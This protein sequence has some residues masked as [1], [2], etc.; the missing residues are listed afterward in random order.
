MFQR[1]NDHS[2]FAH[3][4]FTQLQARFPSSSLITELVQIHGEQF[5]VRA[6]V[7]VSGTTLATGMAA[8]SSI[9]QAEDQARSRA[10]SVVGIV[11]PPVPPLP[12]VQPL[13]NGSSLAGPSPFPQSPSPAATLAMP[14]ALAVAPVSPVPPV[15]AMPPIGGLNPT[16]EPESKVEPE[17]N[18]TSKFSFQPDI[19]TAATIPP[20]MDAP[21]EPIPDDQGMISNSTEFEQP[22][23]E[24]PEELI[25][26]PEK[27]VKA[28]N[29]LI[30]A[31]KSVKSKS[32]STSEV[33]ADGAT[34]SSQA[35]FQAEAGIESH[36][37]DRGKAGDDL[38]PAIAS[39]P[40]EFEDLSSLI[41]FTD[42]EMERVGWSK[43]EGR[44]YLKRTYRKS[45][46]QKL[47]VDELLDFLNYLKALP[48]SNGI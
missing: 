24:Q 26:K 45:T 15:A 1:A 31:E 25:A 18:S 28:S 10:L 20:R 13:I 5:I 22:E 37:R 47:D 19:P 14:S 2:P 8:A 7:Q 43:Q 34:G 9:E 40:D 39:P 4:L 30:K 17:I 32:V 48:S 44:E 23:F 33:N 38:Q 27:P 12:S 46:R 41:A 42:V 21:L 3:S 35:A 36:S 16:L 11:I 29:K 6:L